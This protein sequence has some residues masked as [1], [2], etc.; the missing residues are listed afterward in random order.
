M[1]FILGL[2]PVWTLLSLLNA[3]LFI[4]LA[5]GLK[6]PPP[7]PP[8]IPE[9]FPL[10]HSTFA[11]FSYEKGKLKQSWQAH[12]NIETL[13]KNAVLICDKN[14]LLTLF[15]VDFVHGFLCEQQ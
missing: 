13:L 14:I 9:I 11:S 8:L 1:I 7:R 4:L 10:L 6:A 15:M 12:D 3:E 5:F 2:V